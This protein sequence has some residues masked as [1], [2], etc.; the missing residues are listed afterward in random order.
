MQPLPLPEFQNT[1]ITPERT[2]VPVSS[3]SI[4]PSPPPLVPAGLLSFFL[5]FS[6][7]FAVTVFFAALAPSCCVQPFSSVHAWAS[8]CGGC[9]CC[10]AQALVFVVHGFSCPTACGIFPDSG[11]N[12]LSLALQGKFLT[13]QEVPKKVFSF[14]FFNKR[15]IYVM[16]R[17]WGSSLL[18]ALCSCGELASGVAARKLSSWG[19]QA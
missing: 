13:P 19:G 16:F 11:S 18:R 14:F 7:S 12:W 2:P 9:S 10:K 1:A 5:F 6:D 15:F 4:L 17:L 3:H 8:H